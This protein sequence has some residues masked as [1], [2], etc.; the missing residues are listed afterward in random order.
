MTQSLVGHASWTSLST[1]SEMTHI[2]KGKALTWAKLRMVLP[3]DIGLEMVM[4]RLKNSGFTPDCFNVKPK[5]RV[6]V[7]DA[8]TRFEDYQEMH[9]VSHQFRS[10]VRN[11]RRALEAEL[12]S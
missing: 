1:G 12:W 8:L 11:F 7:A 3:N 2:G 10:R 6:V 5:A 9:F 4:S